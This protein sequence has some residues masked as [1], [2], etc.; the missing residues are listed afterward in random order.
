MYRQQLGI[1][2]V[3]LRINNIYGPNQ[4]DNFTIQG[5]G[6]QLRSWL[7]ADDASEGIRAAIEK[8]AEVDK[9]LGREP[10]PVHFVSIPD[11]PYNDLRYLIDI[12]KA[13]D[14]LGW[15]PKIPFKEGI[16]V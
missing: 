2:M 5:S 16:S 3:I 1:P 7:Y 9:Q 14:E 12:T 15:S 10:S 13:H 11:R 4:W 6:K 8:G